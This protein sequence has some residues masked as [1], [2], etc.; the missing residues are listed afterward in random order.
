MSTTQREKINVPL[1]LSKACSK[2]SRQ[3]NGR[4]K[5]K[6]SSKVAQRQAYCCLTIDC[7]DLQFYRHRLEISSEVISVGV[8]GKT[9]S[10]RPRHNVLVLIFWLG[11]LELKILKYLFVCCLDIFLDNFPRY[12]VHKSL[13][14]L[15]KYIANF[16]KGCINY[17][18][19]KQ[20][21]SQVHLM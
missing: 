12:T 2:L 8:E 21:S 9:F 19:T 1:L 15:E 14:I 5:C 6:A 16:F 10:K 3:N 13:K 4:I 18:R 11:A 17:L 7:V 20:T